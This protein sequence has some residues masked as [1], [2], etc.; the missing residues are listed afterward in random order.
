M[1]DQ[2]RQLPNGDM[3]VV[4]E[5][6][7]QREDTVSSE[8][9]APMKKLD[10]VAEAIAKAQADPQ[11]PGIECIWCGQSHFENEK[12]FT[13]HVRKEHG[14]LFGDSA[15][16]ARQE[17]NDRELQRRATAQGVKRGSAR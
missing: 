16:K 5:K 2:M 7:H 14:S 12:V 8:G 6:G 4:R 3:Y 17:Q 11:R 13:D 10:P 15:E 9:L 1:A